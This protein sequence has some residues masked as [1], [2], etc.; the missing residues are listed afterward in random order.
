[1]TAWRTCVGCHLQGKPCETRN[2]MR[3]P[4]KG[5]GVTS[6]K[7]KCHEREPRYRVGGPVWALKRFIQAERP[8]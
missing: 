6:T 4:L 1:M 8:R 3:K 5:L 2:D 7:W